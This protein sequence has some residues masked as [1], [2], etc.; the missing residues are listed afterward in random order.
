M[1][2]DK[3]GGVSTKAKDILLSASPNDIVKIAPQ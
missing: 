2:V 3:F 1:T